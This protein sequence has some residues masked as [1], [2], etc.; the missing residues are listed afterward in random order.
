[1]GTAGDKENCSVCGAD[2]KNERITYTQ[3]IGDRVY[4]VREV[5]AQVCTQCGE[6]YLSPS[7]VDAIQEA[8]ERGRAIKTVKVPVYDLSSVPSHP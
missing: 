4:I 6:V 1:M 5:P 2:L 3:T 7:T 8:I